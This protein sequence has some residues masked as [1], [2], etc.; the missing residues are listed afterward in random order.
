M[1][2]TA[3][4]TSVS[5]STGT[6]GT[7]VQ[8][9]GSNFL[10][11]GLRGVV[12]FSSGIT[13]LGVTSYTNTQIIVSVPSGAV[14]GVVFLEFAAGNSNTKPFTVTSPGTPTISSLSPNNGGIGSLV[15]INGTNFGPS[16]GQSVVSFNNIGPVIVSWTN[17]A[18]KVTVPPT[19][20]TGPVFVIVVNVA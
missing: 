19:A 8:I 20:T 14:T 13:A 12:V 17:T 3:N 18:I 16:Q 15:T 1:P 9:N 6:V 5:P 4:I 11:S 10:Q 7:H 2:V